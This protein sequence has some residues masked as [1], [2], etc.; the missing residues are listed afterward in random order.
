[1]KRWNVGVL[2]V[3]D[4]GARGERIDRSGE[5]IR[6]M[7]PQMD[8]EVVVSEIVPD[9][10]LTIRRQLIYFADEIKVDLIVTTGGTGFAPR[11]VTPEA[12]RSV[13]EK[14]V[15]GLS[16]A[17][18]GSSLQKT[19][20]ALLSRAVTGIRGTTLIINLPGS[21]KAVRE[22]LEAIWDVLPHGLE[23]LTGEVGDHD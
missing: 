3:S 2:T 9:D 20:Y 12:T 22:C 10:W 14:E 11:D 18:R 23:V 19:R 7:I 16:E 1:M 13:L 15:P 21:P 8:G 4:K 17:M 5:E 6:R